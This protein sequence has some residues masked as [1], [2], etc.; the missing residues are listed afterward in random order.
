MRTL[1]GHK[2]TADKIL[3]ALNKRSFEEYKEKFNRDFVSE[4]TRIRIK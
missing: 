2:G 4:S 1:D 3:K